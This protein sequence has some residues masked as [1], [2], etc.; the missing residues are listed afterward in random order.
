MTVVPYYDLVEEPFKEPCD[1]PSGTRT[2]PT[3]ELEVSP[4][5]APPPP[6]PPLRQRAMAQFLASYPY[7][8]PLLSK[9]W[10]VKILPKHCEI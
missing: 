3:P 10:L 8:Y 4:S 7:W 2:L 5:R 6:A 9:T 1:E